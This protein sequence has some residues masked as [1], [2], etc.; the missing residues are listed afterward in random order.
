MNCH[1][2]K[3]HSLWQVTCNKYQKMSQYKINRHTN[4]LKDKILL[5]LHYWLKWVPLKMDSVSS[6]LKM[7]NIFYLVPMNVIKSWKNK[8]GV[9]LHWMDEPRLIIALQIL[10]PLWLLFYIHVKVVFYARYILWII[11][12]HLINYTNGNTKLVLR[13]EVCM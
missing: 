1:L 9:I 10:P 6:I 8:W 5:M 11:P 12:E 13:A 2:I 7:Y 4:M 3:R